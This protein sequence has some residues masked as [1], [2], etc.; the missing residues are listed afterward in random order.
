MDGKFKTRTYKAKTAK[1]LCVMDKFFK[2]NGIIEPDVAYRRLRYYANT[3]QRDSLQ[4][5]LQ[6]GKRIFEFLFGLFFKYY[7]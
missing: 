7:F 4:A 3:S 6:K 1:I 2:A 5:T